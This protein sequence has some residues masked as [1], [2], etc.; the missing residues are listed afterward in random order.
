MTGLVE[1]LRS[2]LDGIQ[3]QAEDADGWY[4]PPLVLRTVQAHREILDGYVEAVV[5]ADN[6][7]LPPSQHD[8]VDSL[9]ASMETVV[10]VIAGI[11]RESFPGFDPSWLGE[12]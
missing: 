12:S 1:W 4:W 2:T 10:E 5:L 8:A 9:A 6:P 3:G 7:G 11:Y